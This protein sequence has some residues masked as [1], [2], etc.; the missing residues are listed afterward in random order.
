MNAQIGQPGQLIKRGSGTEKYVAASIT[1]VNGDGTVDIRTMGGQD[2]GNLPYAQVSD[3]APAGSGDYFR[4]IA[5][6]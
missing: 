5:L 2:A 6:A 4:E 3:P 1:D